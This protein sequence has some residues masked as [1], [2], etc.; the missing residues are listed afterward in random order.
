MTDLRYDG[1][2]AI[3][4]GAGGNPGLGRSYAM[5]LAAR[6]AKVLVNDYCVGP[7]GRG[8]ISGTPDQVVDAI[9]AAGGEALANYDSV[10]TRD[11][12]SKIV[13][14]AI[15]AWG[16]VDILINNAGIAPFA[17]FDEISDAD[18]ERVV[19]VHLMGTIWMSRASWPHMRAQHYGRIVNVMSTVA[20]GGV[21]HQAIYSGAKL[22]IFGLTQGLALEGE[23]HGIGANLVMPMADTLAWQTMLDGAFSDEARQAN[24]VPDLVAPVAAWLAHETCSYNG[25]CLGTGAGA[26]HEIFISRTK[27]TEPDPALTLESVGTKLRRARDRDG[28]IEFD[29]GEG[30][31]PPNF[32]PKPYNAAPR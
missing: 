2:V 16:R 10:A 15:D 8:A 28:A 6:G 18:I 17:L 3:V 26:I 30:N 20:L 29:P 22:G 4:T 13:A 25:R 27:G 31:L 12:A 5:L 21:T 11:G 1:R 7:D 32:Q 14:D 24:F 19:D 9:R 23:R